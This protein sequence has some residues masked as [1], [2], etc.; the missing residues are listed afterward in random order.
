MD[1]L[2]LL[3]LRAVRLAKIFIQIRIELKID[4]LSLKIYPWLVGFWS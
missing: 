2:N 1:S 3:N 4:F